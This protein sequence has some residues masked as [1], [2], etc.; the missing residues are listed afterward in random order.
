MSQSQGIEGRRP[1]RRTIAKGAAWAVPVIAIGASAPH[2]AAS[3]GPIVFT[4]LS[5]KQGGQSGNSNFTYHMEVQVTIPA[6]SAG[7]VSIQQIQECSGSPTLT[8]PRAYDGTTDLTASFT[9]APGSHT[10][11]LAGDSTNSAM[12]CFTVL[13]TLDGVQYSGTYEF[14]TFKVCCTSSPYCPGSV[15]K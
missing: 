8:S 14:G 12:S 10:L 1:S 5:C 3:G 6:G 11:D 2:A 13:Y 7:Q 9:L 4:G 15:S